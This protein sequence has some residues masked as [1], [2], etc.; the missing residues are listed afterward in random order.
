[1]T[2]H[3]LLQRVVVVW[4]HRCSGV[5]WQVGVCERARTPD[6]AL[7]HWRLFREQSQSHSE[8]KVKE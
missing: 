2:G 8:S 7:R 3:L 4:G 5:G 1:M 6:V